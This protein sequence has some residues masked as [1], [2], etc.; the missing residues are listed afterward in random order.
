MKFGKV[1]NPEEIDFTLPADHPATK[2]VFNTFGGKVK[3][4]LPK[5]F[6]GCAKWN[7]NDLKNFYPKGTKDELSYYSKQFILNV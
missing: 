2:Q 7:K 3:E 4:G 6:V 1:T 5:I